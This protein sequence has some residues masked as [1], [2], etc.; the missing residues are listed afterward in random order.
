M[1]TA[2]WATLIAFSRIEAKRRQDEDGDT[3]PIDVI[4]QEVIIEETTLVDENAILVV[5]L[6]DRLDRLIQLRDDQDT[7][8]PALEQE[9]TDLQNQIGAIE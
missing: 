6:Q 4:A 8:R 3:R 2:Q 9:I 1:T 5:V 7:N